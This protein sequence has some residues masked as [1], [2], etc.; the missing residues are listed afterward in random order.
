MN[1]NDLQQAATA[2][3]YVLVP[4]DVHE[5]LVADALEAE[6][7]RCDMALLATTLVDDAL[8]AGLGTR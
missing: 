1:L 7:L 4:T 6:E 8:T 5:G 3:G 2:L